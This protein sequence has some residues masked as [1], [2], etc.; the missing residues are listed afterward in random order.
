MQPTLY[1]RANDND[2]APFL[3]RIDELSYRKGKKRWK[4]E[5]V[6]HLDRRNARSCV[7][8]MADPRNATHLITSELHLAILKFHNRALRDLNDPGNKRAGSN[9]QDMSP[10]ERFR[11]AVRLTQWHYQWVIVHDF[12]ERLVGTRTVTDL[13]AGKVE[14]V[15]HWK[16]TPYIPI[17]FSAGAYRVGHAMLG[18][19]YRLNGDKDRELGLYDLLGVRR[20]GRGRRVR[21]V[22]TNRH[23]RTMIAWR[24]L[25]PVE[26]QP[27][28]QESAIFQPRF[29]R[30]LAKLPTQLSPDGDE[31]SLVERDLI[32][33][34]KLGLPSGQSIAK[35]L[36]YRV[37]DSR[38]EP[39]LVYL[40]KEAAREG[41]RGRQLGPV[42]GRLVAEVI[43]GLLEGDPTSYLH[44]DP[45]WRP[46]F[47]HDRRRGFDLCAF[48]RHAR[49]PMT[50][51]E[52]PW[53][54]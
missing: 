49:M 48:L 38:H 7:P 53:N 43:L 8:V 45:E 6:P 10:L 54:L 14:R 17:E 20:R 25:V 32:R 22:P 33:S 44:L 50:D 26:G 40:L 15:F 5:D 34:W 51:D 3:F 39:L 36:G 21:Y 35:A 31:T 16:N 47:D 41:R 46:Q 28:P 2:P 30:E 37:S 27:R 29:A 52:L 1:E 12:L 24:Y 13:L 18:G 23:Q 11:E 9:P 19:S 42:G 4:E